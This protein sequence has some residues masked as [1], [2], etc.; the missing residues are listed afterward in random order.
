MKVFVIINSIIPEDT[1]VV[2]VSI[3]V[4]KVVDFL[5]KNNEYVELTVEVWENE[6]N[7]NEYIHYNKLPEDAEFDQNAIRNELL[8]QR[9]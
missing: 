4:G 1:E 5:L 7:V 6:N 3:D 2:L 9:Y 8:T